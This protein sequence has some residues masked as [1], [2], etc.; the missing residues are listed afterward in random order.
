MFLDKYLD[1][2]YLEQV[3]SN[4]N[5]NY[6]QSLDE[7]NFNK[8]YKVFQKHGFYFIEDIIENYIHLFTIDT[9]LL[10]SGIL[11]LKEKLGDNFVYIIGDDLSFLDEIEK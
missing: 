4:Y 10:E 7:E 5:L 2:Y 1:E 9:K 8:I 11:K 3:Y 6:L